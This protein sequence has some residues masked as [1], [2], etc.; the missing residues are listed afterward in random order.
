MEY[1][2]RIKNR[3]PKV[4]CKNWPR[5]F[6][7]WI[8]ASETIEYKGYAHRIYTEHTALPVSLEVVCYGCGVIEFNAKVVSDKTNKSRPKKQDDVS[9]E[10]V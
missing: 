1:E 2:G 6:D 7:T 4:H 3:K 5:K 9:S 8:P 10:M